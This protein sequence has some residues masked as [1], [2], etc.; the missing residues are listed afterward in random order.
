MREKLEKLQM[1]YLDGE[2][3]EIS[4]MEYDTMVKDSGVNEEEFAKL[5]KLSNEL[6]TIE[7]D[8]PMMSIEKKQDVE[9][10]LKWFKNKGFSRR[11]RF[12]ASAKIDGWAANIEYDKNG[13]LLSVSTRG[14][15]F[16]G[17]ILPA[18]PMVPGIR[19]KIKT[20]AALTVR[21]EI[22]LPFSSQFSKNNKNS[23]NFVA[24][25]RRKEPDQKLI[26][27]LKFFAYGVYG[28]DKEFNTNL[29]K[30]TYLK[31]LGFEIPFHDI[32]V[33][34]EE[35]IKD[36]VLG[37]EKIIVDKLEY[38]CD[39][40]VFQVNK[41]AI[42]EEMEENS[43]SS[44]YVASSIAFKYYGA[45][46]ISKIGNIHYEVGRTGHITPILDIDEVIIK[47]SRVK[48]ISMYNLDMLAKYDFHI[49]DKI[50]VSM[51][52]EVLP[53]FRR[54]YQ[55]END[56]KKKIGKIERCPSCNSLLEGNRC[57]QK[58]C[59]SKNVAAIIFALKTM[60]VMNIDKKIVETAFDA[61]DF[62]RIHDY[63][64][65]NNS[66]LVEKLSKH[67]GLALA[68]K[69]ANGIEESRK[70]DD[71][72]ILASLGIDR[73]S[74]AT[75]TRHKIYSVNDLK[76]YR[77]INPELIRHKDLSAFVRY[78]QD[79]DNYTDILEFHTAVRQNSK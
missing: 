27:E 16:T 26:R 9:S 17:N 77:N 43:V 14:D 15:G 62:Q 34:S 78:L 30:F 60:K 31:E 48:N 64:N 3:T 39:G 41:C 20:N 12:L 5:G 8:P 23:R 44:K 53:R 6:Q 59:R 71:R 45:E 22:V 32:V 52:N 46:A 67:S 40:L 76:H 49:G 65:I 25:I 37:F 2:E 56:E 29:D 57:V 69:I 19:N 75:L 66:D 61:K 47:G 18:A 13:K 50:V 21:G 24:C 4:D 68:R 63:Y 54:I 28:Q 38:P 33:A 1:K 58:I 11:E 79:N 51:A 42:Q 7:H 55:S 35:N 70:L 72:H 36:M 74:Y 73:I 10:L